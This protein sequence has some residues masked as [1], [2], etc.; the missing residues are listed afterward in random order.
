MNLVPYPNAKIEEPA[1]PPR[2]MRPRLRRREAAEYLAM[3]HGFG[4]AA[5]TLAKLASVGGGPAFNRIG[6]TPFYPIDELDRWVEERIGP[7]VRSTSDG[8]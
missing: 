3:R 1:L 4:I 2:L 8:R 7:L 5:A 6:R